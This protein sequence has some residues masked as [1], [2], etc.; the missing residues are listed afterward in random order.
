M[1]PLKFF[2]YVKLE[3]KKIVDKKSMI[4]TASSYKH[5]FEQY[6]WKKNEESRKKENS[7]GRKANQEKGVK[8]K[9][10]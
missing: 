10:K 2:Q 1:T 6:C 5:E 3:S 7:E 4:P 8:S 9:I